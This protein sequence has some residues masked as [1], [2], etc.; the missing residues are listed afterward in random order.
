M[1]KKLTQSQ[2][3]TI[4]ERAVEEFGRNGL[5]RAAISEIARRSGISVGVIYKYYENKDALFEACLKR[6]LE[7]LK[8]VLD[9]A[10][11]GEE[12]LLTACE[13]L[14]RAC[15]SFA[16]D[17]SPYIQMYNALTIRS[18]EEAAHYANEIE[19]LTSDTYK[20]LIAQAVEEGLVRKDLD[21]SYF[22]FFFDNL[23]M[24]LHFTYSCRYY[25]ERMKIYLGPEDEEKM[26]RQLM[27]FIRGAFTA[28]D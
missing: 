1:L 17:H 18:D 28:E 4:L 23:L 10:V 7:M 8:D 13:K 2:Q 6:S 19:K 15:I 27:L 24:M 12:D 20:R 11:L 22:A 14:I 9:Q 21:P 26:V 16:R 25:E 5:E 3:D